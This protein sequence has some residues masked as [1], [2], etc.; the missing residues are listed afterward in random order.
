MGDELR[1]PGCDSLSGEWP[2]DVHLIQF[3][4]LILSKNIRLIISG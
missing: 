4:L 1:T 3:I 2:K